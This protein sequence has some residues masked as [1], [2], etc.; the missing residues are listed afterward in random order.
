MGGGMGPFSHPLGGVRV[1]QPV[2]GCLARTA[3]AEAAVPAL[4]D[5]VPLCLPV[6]HGAAASCPAGVGL[7]VSSCSKCHVQDW[8]S[9]S[10]CC[11]CVS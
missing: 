4:S 9:G 3:C 1:K 10:G 7:L 2:L 8:V 6:F 5:T 11:T